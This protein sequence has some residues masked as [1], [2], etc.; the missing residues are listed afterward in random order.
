[1]ASD[2]YIAHASRDRPIAG[3]IVEAL[4]ARGV[5]CFDQNRDIEPGVSYQEVI[6]QAIRSCKL[7]VVVYS[8][9]A[10]AS[11]Y[12]AREVELA[13][14]SGLPIIPVRI[15]R[16]PPSGS[17]SYFLS[18]A[19]WI[20]AEDGPS[21]AQL[22][23]LVG[24]VIALLG[25][26]AAADAGAGVATGGAA[27]AQVSSSG[28]LDT[29]RQLFGALA[30]RP[31]ADDAE[32][33]R[34]REQ[35]LAAAIADEM[36]APRV[37]DIA[38]RSL[39]T[40]SRAALAQARLDLAEA[41]DAVSQLTG[42]ALALSDP[43]RQVESLD[44]AQ[45]SLS[46][47]RSSLVGRDGPLTEGLNALASEWSSVL[48]AAR[49]AAVA[50]AEASREIDNP[51]IFGNPVQAQ[52]E[53]LFTGRGD[54]VQEIERNILRAAQTPTLLLYGQRR[55]GKTS[56]LNQLPTL[57]GPGF[58]PTL[59]D[60]Q[61]PAM[62]ESPAALLRHLSRCLAAALNARLRLTQA[63]EQARAERGAV[64]LSL[65]ALA[66]APYSAFEDWLDAF[67]ERLPADVRVLMC[68]DEFERLQETLAAGW[69]GRFLDAL[70]HW[71]QHR[72]AFS[73][74][75]VGSH[76]FE[77]L[78]PAW[79]DRFLSAR[80]LKVSFL[81][82][83]DVRRLLTQPTPNFRLTYGPGA[84]DAVVAAT[85]GQPFLTQ[86]LAS[87]LVH[88]M[89]RQRRTQALA[90]DVEAA[91]DQTLERSAEY[92]FDLWFSRTD[93]ERAVLLDA[94]RGRV[95][96]PASAVER[97]LRDYD[98]LTDRGGYA[99]PLVRRWVETVQLQPGAAPA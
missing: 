47:I 4:E 83:A 10:E 37:E 62:A 98:I 95:R 7:A 60:C 14:S 65:G 68:L 41:F 17:W 33:E 97:G 12:V 93:E 40:R 86:A 36:S 78:G 15:D 38:R 61:A 35:G 91:I 6:V 1:M 43:G 5:R 9:S 77:Q 25:R 53:G 84:L 89:N 19:A 59:V 11:Q 96:P 58:L 72:P 39:S 29:L 18:G 70:R 85:H 87:E 82:D 67:S 2:V 45:Q 23:Q 44:L 8:A 74:M 69:G 99:V 79:T 88:H 49:E 75:F 73:L 3:R 50:R 27:D 92:F 30:G 63:D 64:A 46:Q 28:L 81:A 57:L 22:D 31:R 21:E 51:F 90:A 66:E 20:E 94:A 52:S 24:A 76:T 42:Q 26:T 34:A 71:L 56:I 13:V 32:A 48:A 55:M 54:V 16:T 80:R